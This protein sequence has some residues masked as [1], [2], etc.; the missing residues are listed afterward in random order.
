MFIKVLR[1]RAAFTSQDKTYYHIKDI[2][3]LAHE[4]IL[5]KVSN[6]PV[7]TVARTSANRRHTRPA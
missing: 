7:H 4:P 3:Y 2:T 6:A 5:Q 1:P